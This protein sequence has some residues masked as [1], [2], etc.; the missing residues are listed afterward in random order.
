MNPL[1]SLGRMLLILGGALV[2]VALTLLLLARVPLA[3]RL[4]GDFRLRWGNVSCYFPLVT[5]VI[6][7]VLATLVLNLILWLLR[8]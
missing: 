4:P 1:E 5:G 6:V 2:V 7:S 3:G 8:K